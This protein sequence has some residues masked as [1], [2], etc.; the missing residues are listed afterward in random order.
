MPGMPLNRQ[1]N[2]INEAPCC[3]YENIPDFLKKIGD[4][5]YLLIVLTVPQHIDL[6]MYPNSI[7]PA[8]HYMP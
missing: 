1:Q 8:V 6:G 2:G 5:D 4:V 7:R 3:N